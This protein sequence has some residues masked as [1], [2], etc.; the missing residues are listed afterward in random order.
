[1]DHANT[2]KII[3]ID[4]SEL[5]IYTNF[6]NSTNEKDIEMKTVKYANKKFYA[7]VARMGGK[8]RDIHAL[9]IYEFKQ[10]GVPRKIGEAL[11]CVANKAQN[12]ELGALTKDCGYVVGRPTAAR[13]NDMSDDELNRL[14]S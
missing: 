5:L 10:N 3:F 2:I 7:L 12:I 11:N 6:I 13:M 9:A 8:F 1:M 14:T 4:N